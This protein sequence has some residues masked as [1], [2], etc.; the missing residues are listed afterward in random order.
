MSIIKLVVVAI[1]IEETIMNKARQSFF[2][3]LS[4]IVIIIFSSDEIYSQTALGDDQV[5]VDILQSS[6]GGGYTLQPTRSFRDVLGT[7]SMRSAGVDM[8]LPVYESPAG[9]TY[10]KELSMILLRANALTI[11]PAISG[12]CTAA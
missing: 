6:I 8:T 10:D 1:H 12:T 5:K 2:C 9:D 11:D 3:F 4:S 7:Y